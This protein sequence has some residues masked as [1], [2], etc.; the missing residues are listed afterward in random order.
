[1]AVYDRRVQHALTTLGLTL[2][3]TPGRYGRYLQLLDDLLR[4]GRPHADGWTARD[5]DTAL[6]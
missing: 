6:Y 1:M 4:H 2:T 5:I 3:P